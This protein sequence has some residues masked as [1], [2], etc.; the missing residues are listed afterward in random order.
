M[1]QRLLLLV[2]AGAAAIS[3]C[4]TTAGYRGHG[5]GYYGSSS[6][7]RYSQSY[8][9]GYYGGDQH[10]YGYDR[11]GRPYATYGYGSPY[12]GSY[13]GYGYP[14]GYYDPYYGNRYYYYYPPQYRPPNSGSGTNNPPP[15]TMPQVIDPSGRRGSTVSPR[16]LPPDVP[17]RDLARYRRAQQVMSS[18]SMSSQSH[19]QLG[20]R[21]LQRT[22]PQERI[23]SMPRPHQTL[24]DRGEPRGAMPSTPSSDPMDDVRARK[25]GSGR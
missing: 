25:G 23:Q 19:E 24:P 15:S 13:Y 10:Y 12:G 22:L 7:D 3:G 18:Q 9:Y 5:G 17:L 21:Q 8:P 20:P 1:K 6:D 2:L 4:V 11:Y 14:Y 16:G